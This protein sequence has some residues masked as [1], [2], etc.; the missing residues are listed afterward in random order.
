[1]NEKFFHG[2]TDKTIQNYQF[3]CMIR[4][5]TLSTTSNKVRNDNNNDDGDGGC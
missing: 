5:L 4:L 2:R 1:M 3:I